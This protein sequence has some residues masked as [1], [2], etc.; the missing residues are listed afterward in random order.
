MTSDQL[1]EAI[2]DV[3]F[4]IEHRWQPSQKAALFLIARKPASK[5]NI[6]DFQLK[7]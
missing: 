7:S 4:V 5:A 6:G 1:V 2:T 3:G